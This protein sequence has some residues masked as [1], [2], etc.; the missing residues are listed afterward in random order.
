MNCSFPP[1]VFR[2]S[3]LQC[4]T[5]FLF[6]A[7]RRVIST[8][9]R[10]EY[11]CGDPASLT[12]II[13]VSIDDQCDKRGATLSELPRLSNPPLK[14]MSIENT[15]EETSASIKAGQPSTKF[16]HQD[17]SKL[18]IVSALLKAS[19]FHPPFFSGCY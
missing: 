1:Q 2:S 6:V 4:H 17:V 16:V 10:L 14:H 12:C 11:K 15:M 8:P 9:D 13:Q 5:L 18:G 3:G 19:S 7:Y